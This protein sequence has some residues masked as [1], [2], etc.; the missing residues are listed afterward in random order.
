MKIINPIG[1]TISAT[2]PSG[3]MERAC[4]CSVNGGKFTSTRNA[5][6]GCFRCGCDCTNADYAASGNSMT[7]F[8]KIGKS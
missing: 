2:G 8:L 6:E 4:A 1:R 5:S 3:P 7:A